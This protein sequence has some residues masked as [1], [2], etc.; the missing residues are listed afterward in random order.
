MVTCTVVSQLKLLTVT[1]T[2]LKKTFV[3]CE[4]F[5]Q[6]KNGEIFHIIFKQK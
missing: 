3:M 6:Y 5:K 1:E 2:L 4:H